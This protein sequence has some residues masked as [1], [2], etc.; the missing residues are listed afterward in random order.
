MTEPKDR[1]EKP[2]SAEIARI[3]AACDDGQQHAIGKEL[4]RSILDALELARRERDDA[5][6][7]PI[8]GGRCTRCTSDAVAEHD[9]DDCLAVIRHGEAI[10]HTRLLCER[11][12]LVTA[13][14]RCEWAR[15]CSSDRFGHPAKS[16]TCPFCL[17]RDDE[18][19]TVTCEMARLI[20]K[21][22]STT[23]GA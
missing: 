6:H 20:V 1:D 16:G 9:F 22:A 23:G 21:Y 3:R 7:A 10:T 19:H 13:I 11:D 14:R 17:R 5:R 8:R 12:A 4:V 18:G 15:G 2:T